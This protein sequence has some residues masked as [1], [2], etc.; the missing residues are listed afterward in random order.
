MKN[1]KHKDTVINDKYKNNVP[2]ISLLKNKAQLK[3]I[4]D[5]KVNMAIIKINKLSVI[6]IYSPPIFSFIISNRVCVSLWSID[7][8]L[9][10]VST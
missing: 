10:K 7:S 5:I 9:G 4:K 8:Q 6:I 1:I 2:K 3:N